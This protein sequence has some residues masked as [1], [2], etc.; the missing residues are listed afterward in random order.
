MML[1]QHGIKS[2][3]RPDGQV[4]NQASILPKGQRQDA[5][6]VALGLKIED[7]AEPVSLTY[8]VFV[9]GDMQSW[10]MIIL[11]HLTWPLSRARTD[12]ILGLL[13]KRA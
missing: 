4:S 12:M 9:I 6:A 5:Q 11:V 1:G 7:S 3:S 10:I 2:P 13:V 8:L